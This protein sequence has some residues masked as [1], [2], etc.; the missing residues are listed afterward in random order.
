[1]G[2]REREGKRKGEKARKEKDRAG[3]GERGKEREEGGRELRK[4]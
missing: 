3:G 4:V 1:V 2:V